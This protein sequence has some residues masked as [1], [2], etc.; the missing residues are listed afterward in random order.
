MRPNVMVRL[1]D[2]TDGTTQTMV[3]TEDAGRPQLWRAGQLVPDESLIC[4]PWSEGGACNILLNG[5]TPNGVT[6]PGP[7]AM[8]CT[9]KLEIYSFHP[10]GA[11]ALFADGSVRFLKAS[12]DI[13]IVARLVTMAAGEAVSDSDF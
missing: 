13:R 9:N 11:N 6:K 5:S 7:C 2:I 3:I 10:G 12:V 8:N 1:A 4:G